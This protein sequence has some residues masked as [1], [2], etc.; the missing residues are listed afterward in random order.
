VAFSL[1]VNPLKFCFLFA[2]FFVPLWPT[3]LTLR[4]DGFP[5]FN[6]QR[7]SLS[8]TF[9]VW[10][11]T[12]LLYGSVRAR[13]FGVYRK[14]RKFFFFLFVFIFFQFLSVFFSDT[15]IKSL[16]S[17]FEYFLSF[18]VPFVVTITLWDC[19]KKLSTPLRVLLFS[20]FIVCVLGCVELLFERPLFSDLIIA[21]TT[22]LKDAVEPKFRNLVHYRVQSTFVHPLS[23]AQYL[24]LIFPFTLTFIS[25]SRNNIFRLYVF[26]IFFLEIL[27]LY[28]TRTRSSV[29]V[30]FF[31]VVV[32]ATIYAIVY[33]K[34]KGGPL[35]GIIFMSLSSFV[36]FSFISFSLFILPM[37]VGTTAGEEN[38]SLQRVAQLTTGVP[39]IISRPFTG[40]GPGRAASVLNMENESVDNYFLTVSLESGLIALFALVAMFLISISD[41]FRLLSLVGGSGKYVLCSCLVAFVNIL[42]MMS[43]VSLKQFF[44]LIFMF[45]AFV[46]VYKNSVTGASFR[47]NDYARA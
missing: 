18:L 11:V 10:I 40:Y 20:S 26:F 3:Y 21:N 34:K 9:F 33:A 7:F 36:V 27:C 37:I 2:V 32:F 43:I 1:R 39:L 23:F 42:L 5:G 14:N 35:S 29:V 25:L 12:V 6:L 46:V 24:I 16:Y 4:L 38:S 15:K 45:F 44:P 41:S 19:P 47:G 31:V 28:F 13:I 8:F 30:L 22:A 17:S